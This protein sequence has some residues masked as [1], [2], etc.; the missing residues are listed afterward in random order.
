MLELGRGGARPRRYWR[1]RYREPVA[2]PEAE[3]VERVRA[4][5]RTAVA[6]RCP[7][8]TP[9]GV[10][11]SGGLDSTSVALL[12]QRAS[13]PGVRAFSSTFPG[14]PR[15]D[16][17]SW[18]DAVE[19][20]AGIPVVR[21]AAQPQGILASGLEHLACWELP[22]HAWNEAWTQPLLREAAALGIGAVLSGEGGDELFGSRYLLIADLL[23]S[24]R[25]LAA[26]RL[27]RGLPE[28]GGRAPR[29]VLAEILWR[30]G[31][32]GLPSARME[33]AWRRCVSWGNGGAPWWAQPQMRR[34]LRAERQPPWRALEGPRWWAHLADVLTDS[35]HGFGLFDHM[36]RSAEQAGLEARQPLFDLDLLELMLAVPPALCSRGSLTR[37]LL[38]EAMAGI[39]PDA[40]R[41]RPGKSVFDEVVSAALLGP[42]LPALQALLGDAAEVRAYARPEAIAEMVAHPPP[43][44]R[45]EAAAWEDDV[46]RLT[47]IELWLRFQAD[48]ALP[49]RLLE[50][51]LVPPPRHRLMG[52]A[53]APA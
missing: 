18:I 26:A 32:A 37:P 36:R 49:A 51:E 45:G 14:Y 41:L 38:R 9:V 39:S 20:H 13:G 52:P 22:L 6:R 4:G 47:A 44:Q 2:L 3:L 8:D 24:G 53:A 42:E 48:P 50:G 33:S 29:R 11:M 30:F 43:H 40:V 15:V 34:W 12:A 19:A 46:L 5:L 10:L 27:A 35:A 25:P 28:A 16:E 21:F 17:S 1:P 23:R 7:A 31:L